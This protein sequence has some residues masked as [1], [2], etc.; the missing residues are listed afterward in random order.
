LGFFGDFNMGSDGDPSSESPSLKATGSSQAPSREFDPELAGFGKFFTYAACHWTEHFKNCSPDAL[1]SCDDISK[2]ARRGSKVLRNWVET[3]KRPN[4]TLSLQRNLNVEDFDELVVATS[5]GSEAFLTTF[6][7]RRF[8][9]HCIRDKSP[10]DAVKWLMQSGNLSAVK[11]LLQNK[12]LQNRFRDGLF[13]CEI[14][15]ICKD[16]GTTREA[17]QHKWNELLDILVCDFFSSDP[18]PYEWA[19]TLLCSAARQGCLPIIEIMF[20]KAS[21]EPDLA[22]ALLAQTQVDSPY[23]SVGEAAF[24]GHA[25][26]VQYLLTQQHVDISPHLHHRTTRDERNVLHC[27]AAS[28]K[29]ANIVRMLAEK[30]PSGVNEHTKSGDTPLQLLTFGQHASTEAVR[31][32]VEI[33]KADVNLSVGGAWHSPLRTAVRNGHVDVCRLLK[34]YGARVDDALKFDASSGKVML[35]DDVG[36][37]QTAERILEILVERSDT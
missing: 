23:Q 7:E 4:L 32:L 28:S 35:A 1:P 29:N 21:K 12:S 19:N 20:A 22:K 9:A 15:T 26:I 24:W 6:L 17:T 18:P 34:S 33:G 10:A 30:L 16:A 27:A 13:L 11:I 5:F 14:I 31:A 37:V 2:L 3:Y 36:D 8:E 25:D